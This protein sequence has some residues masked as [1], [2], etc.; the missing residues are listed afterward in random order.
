MSY[1]IY[2]VSCVIPTVCNLFKN[3]NERSGNQIKKKTFCGGGSEILWNDTI[4]INI[5][6]IFKKLNYAHIF[7]IKYA[8]KC[9]SKIQS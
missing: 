4:Y 6:K 2:F 9:I 8:L 7:L 3:N 5:A 1:V